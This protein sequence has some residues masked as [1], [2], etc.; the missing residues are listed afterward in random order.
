[1]TETQ[2]ELEREAHEVGLSRGWDHANFVDAYG[3]EHDTRK[4]EY[5]AYLHVPMS[6]SGYYPEGMTV[7][8]M[9]DRLAARK[10]FEAAWKEGRKRFR[11]GQY[12]DGTKIE[13]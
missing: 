8:E 6:R 7:A 2:S 3:K 4:P 11:L 10:V 5:P 13:D 9:N 12:P 1:M